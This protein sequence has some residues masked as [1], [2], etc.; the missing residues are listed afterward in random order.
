MSKFRIGDE[1][2]A[3]SEFR[4][5]WGSN[6]FGDGV[7]IITTEPWGI[8]EDCSWVKWN[9]GQTY[10]YNNGLLQLCQLQENE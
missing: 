1:V 9:N 6:D 3:T 4:K 7:G 8:P 2:V 5:R 10:Y